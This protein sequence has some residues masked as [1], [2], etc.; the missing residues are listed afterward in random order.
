MGVVAARGSCEQSLGWARERP[1][2]LEEDVAGRWAGDS[3]PG[4]DPP[5]GDTPAT[6][7]HPSRVPRPCPGRPESAWLLVARV[8]SPSCRRSGPRGPGRPQPRGLRRSS[9]P[10]AREEGGVVTGGAV[11]P[12]CPD[13]FS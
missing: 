10:A 13:V 8:L 12:L 5:A 3:E 4:W 7:A 9:E 2:H 11:N 1:A 6:A